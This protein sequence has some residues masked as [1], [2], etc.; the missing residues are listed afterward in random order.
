MHAEV[1]NSNKVEKHMQEGEIIR[2]SA[3]QKGIIIWKETETWDL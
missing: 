1:K 2:C 3:T